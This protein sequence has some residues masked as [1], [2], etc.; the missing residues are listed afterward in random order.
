MPG[1][2][3][4][5]PPHTPRPSAPYKPASRSN[6]TPPTDQSQSAPSRSPKSSQCHSCVAYLFFLAQSLAPK[7][8]ATKAALF[9]S[10][11][12]LFHHLP[13]ILEEIMRVMRPRT[14][15]RVILH[16][17]HR[18][19]LMPQPGQRLVVQVR[20]RLLHICRQR[21][22][23]DVEVMVLGRNLNLPRLMIHDRMVPAMVPKLQLVHLASERQPEDLMPQAYPEDRF[24]PLQLLY[25]LNRILQRLRV[26]RSV[27]KEHPI[28]V[29]RQNVLSWR[30]SRHHRHAAIL[31]RQHAQNILF[32]P[33][34]IR[35]HM[36]LL[37]VTL[38]R[39]RQQR[40]A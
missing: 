22:R 38:K 13:K 14:S 26:T 15:L 17:E 7:K 37:R 3:S 4:P 19:G 8:C 29:H 34:V 2:S 6:R 31:P 39:C 11:F 20:M 32:Y 9:A 23:I 40:I 33:E 27:R 18:I 35:D 1:S 30:S 21:I 36:H 25:S 10:F 5:A 24:L 12:E 16:A 28:R